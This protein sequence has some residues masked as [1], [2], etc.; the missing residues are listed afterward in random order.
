MTMRITPIECLSDNYAYLL[1][2]DETG[3]S[4]VIDPSEAPPVLAAIER[5]KARV[6]A[7]W[8]THHHFDHVGGNEEVLA[9]TGAKEIVA[10]A[11]DK[12]RVPGQTRFIEEGDALSVGKVRVS[13]LH[14]PGHTTGAVA[15]VA[16]APGGGPGAV[17]T[18]DMLFLAGCGRI[19]EG[20]PAMMHGS[21]S[22]VAALPE[23]TRVYCGHEYTAS[24]LKFAAHVEPDN[25]QVLARAE[26]VGV[27]RA[28]G[29][30]TVPGVLRDE[31]A[32]NPFLR[33]ASPT[34]RKTLGIPKD[35]SDADALGAI[36]KAKDSF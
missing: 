33:V 7:I 16:A 8:N 11:S 25:A 5:E 31:L 36:R 6:V 12:G 34:I 1:T 20:T 35:A 13:V 9:K 30:P 24:N 29:K 32:T 18:G 2:C 10:H 27:A 28:A 17:F 22:K 21:L 15:Y 23:E 14:I 19:F 26:R 3:D 4:V